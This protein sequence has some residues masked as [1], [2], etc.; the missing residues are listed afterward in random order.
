MMVWSRY[1][2]IFKVLLSVLIFTLVNVSIIPVS[3]WFIIINMILRVEHEETKARDLYN[4][5]LLRK[6][7]ESPD[8]IT[9]ELI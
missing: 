9:N 2:I 4:K 6:G 1:F 5:L 8:S 3:T 7:A